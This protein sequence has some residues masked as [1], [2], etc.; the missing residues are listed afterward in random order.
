MPPPK[1]KACNFNSQSSIGR[2]RLAKGSKPNLPPPGSLLI[3]TGYEL[4]SSRRV[5]RMNLL[6]CPGK[7]PTSSPL[8]PNRFPNERSL[9][10][11]R[12]PMAVC[13][14]IVPRLSWLAGSLRIG[15]IALLGS[16]PTELARSRWH[17]AAPDSGADRTLRRVRKSFLIQVAS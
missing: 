4:V 14:N 1:Q 5:S 9:L 8:L 15:R 7:E 12:C 17:S 3:L 11:V 10:S 6:T 16:V 13:L 2:R